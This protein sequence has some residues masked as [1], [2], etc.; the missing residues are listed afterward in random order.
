MS[1]PRPP[2]PLTPAPTLSHPYRNGNINCR[3]GCRS[4]WGTVNNYHYATPHSYTSVCSAEGR[5]AT[6]FRSPFTLS[7]TCVSQ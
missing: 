5:S 4:F 1:P 3:L 7:D 2:P 6:Q